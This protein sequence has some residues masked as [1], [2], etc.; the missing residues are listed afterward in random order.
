MSEERPTLFGLTFGNWLQIGLIVIGGFGAFVTVQNEQKAQAA[1]FTAIDRH[2]RELEVRVRASEI[3]QS[4]QSSDLRNI[5][6]TLTRI[7]RQL[8][9]RNNP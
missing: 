8:D 2:I 1:Q 5:I 7:E 9:A 4:G 6:A 3:V